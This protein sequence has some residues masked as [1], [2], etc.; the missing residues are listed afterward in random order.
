MV[1]L[2][3]G[4]VLLGLTQGYGLENGVRKVDINWWTIHCKL[5]LLRGW[6]SAADFKVPC[7]NLL[8]P[9]RFRLELALVAG[10]KS[11]Q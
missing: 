6:I 4:S 1:R 11:G 3:H 10:L 7:G 2:D 5:T 8:I 9:T